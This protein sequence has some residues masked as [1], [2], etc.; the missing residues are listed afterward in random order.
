MEFHYNNLVDTL[1]KSSVD[2]NELDEKWV[3]R[4]QIGTL[5]ASLTLNNTSM[6]VLSKPTPCFLNFNCF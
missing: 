5:L 1:D 4:L 2:E 3:Y 6:L